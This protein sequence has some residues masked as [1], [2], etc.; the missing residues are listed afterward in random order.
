MCRT[1]FQ[2]VRG[3]LI[4][5]SWLDGMPLMKFVEEHEDQELRNQIAMTMFRAWYV[6]F[7]YYE[8]STAIR[9]SAT[10]PCGLTAGSSCSTLDASGSSHRLS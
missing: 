7:Y 3:R 9:I 2:S 8:S 5:M 1:S 10:T 4:T 6:P